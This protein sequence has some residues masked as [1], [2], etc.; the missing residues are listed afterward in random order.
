MDFVKK[1]NLIEEGDWSRF[2]SKHYGRIY[3]FQ[4][5]NGCMGRGLYPITVPSDDDNEEYMNDS[6]PEEINGDNMGVKFKVWLERNPKQPLKD[7]ANDYKLRLF[8]ERN[9]YPSID[10]VINDLYEKGFIEAGEYYINIDF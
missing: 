6:I 7:R 3:S 2:V 1:I 4:Q 10:T 5:Q 9:F 8:W